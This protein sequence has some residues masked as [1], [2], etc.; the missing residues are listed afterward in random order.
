MKVFN[1]INIGEHAGSGVPNIFNVWY[2]ASD[3]MNVL[4]GKE[5][6]TKE[7]LRAL[8]VAEKLVDDDALVFKEEKVF[9]SIMITMVIVFVKIDETIKNNLR[10]EV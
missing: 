9:I 7:L 6:R 8:I 3:L 5:T 10:L 4:G 1:L 2:K